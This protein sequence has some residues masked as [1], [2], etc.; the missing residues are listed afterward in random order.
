MKFFSIVMDGEA[1][2][3]LDDDK[4][5]HMKRGDVAV[6]RGTIHGWRNHTEQWSRIYFI[7]TAAEKLVINGQE[8]GDAGYHKRD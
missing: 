8:L 1:W 2:L 4:E 5:I 6:Q 3:V 7:L